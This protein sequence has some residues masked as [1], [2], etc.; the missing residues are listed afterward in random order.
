MAKKKKSSKSAI[1]RGVKFFSA[2]P[3]WW[4]ASILFFVWFL[5]PNYSGIRPIM[6]QIFGNGQVGNALYYSVGTTVSVAIFF[7][8]V[9][10]KQY[11]N[12]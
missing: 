4:L 8:G 1:K 9:G 10:M 3:T 12:N 2:S 7:V 6:D 11:E 5:I